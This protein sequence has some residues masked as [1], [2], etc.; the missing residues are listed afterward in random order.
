MYVKWW[1]LY[2]EDIIYQCNNHANLEYNY[3]EYTKENI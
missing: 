2:E 3:E 1:T